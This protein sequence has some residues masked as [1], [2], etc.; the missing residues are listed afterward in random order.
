MA[1][2]TRQQW[3]GWLSWMNIRGPVGP[4]RQDFYTAYTAFNVMHGGR[5]FG[6]NAEFSTFVEMMPWVVA[7][8]DL[9]NL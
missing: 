4:Q 9:A 3:L 7:E 6:E 2:L 5:Q 8:A 1:V